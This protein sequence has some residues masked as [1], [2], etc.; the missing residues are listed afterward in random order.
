[1]KNI[2]FAKQV[3]DKITNKDQA[4]GYTN[5]DEINPLFKLAQIDEISY[6]VGSAN[7]KQISFY[8]KDSRVTASVDKLKKTK[9]LNLADGVVAQPTGFMLHSSAWALRTYLNYKN[10]QAQERV[11]INMLT[12]NQFD[13]RMYSQIDYPTKSQPI[14]KYA[15]DL[16]YVEPSDISMITLRYLQYPV[17]PIWA[18]TMVDDEEVYNDAASVD[19][20][21]PM[22]C[23]P[24]IVYRVCQYLGIE[25]RRQDLVQIMENFK[26]TQLQ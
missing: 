16:I 21:L 20:V 11:P 4:S 14:L 22:L 7:G 3:I 24:N 19:F 5:G 2:G 26:A 25:I 17:D 18:F 9:T 15:D 10:E 6:L 13:E 23:V 1:V 12:D 8:E